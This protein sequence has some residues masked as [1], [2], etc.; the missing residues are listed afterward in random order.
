MF[1]LL[2]EMNLT[3]I[4][5]DSV[6]LIGFGGPEKPEDV[7]PFLEDVTR[8]RNIPH[9]RLEK[10]VE[11]YKQIG[12]FSPYSQLTQFQ[13][14]CLQKLLK[15]RGMDIPV[16]V[17]FA[18]SSPTISKTLES[19]S[20]E[21]KKNIFAIIMAPFRSQVSFTKYILK[22]DEAKDALKAAG[23]SVPE[24]VYA[25]EWHNR[26]GFIRAIEQ[27]IKIAISKLLP[28]EKKAAKAELIFSTHSIP[29]AVANQSSYVAQFEETARLVKEKLGWP[30]FHLAYTSRSG[31]PED[32]WLEPDLG[33]FLE[34]RSKE[35][36]EACVVAPIGFLVNHAEVLYDIDILAYSRAKKVGI[37]MVRA[38]TVGTRPSFIGMLVSLVEEASDLKF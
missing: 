21:G 12:G 18:H 33:D 8:G 16:T 1:Y 28:R 37:N 34:R 31:R 4:K 38:E 14:A 23:Q 30:Y 3:Q 7:L 26:P 27:E 24:V 20:R 17:G 29:S 9:E 15:A 19:L 5:F 25:P 6:L 36:L 32:R 13:A 11:Q 2:Q 10:V 35:G 22:V